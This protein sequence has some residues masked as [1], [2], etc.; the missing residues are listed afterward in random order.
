MSLFSFCMFFLL[1]YLFIADST[2]NVNVVDNDE[3]SAQFTRH[4]PSHIM[5]SQ[6]KKRNYIPVLITIGR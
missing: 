2:K 3:S 5:K 4:I 6:Q 1:N